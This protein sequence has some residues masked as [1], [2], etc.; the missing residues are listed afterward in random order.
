METLNW[1]GAL[2]SSYVMDQL[3]DIF[4]EGEIEEGIG[5]IVFFNT[6]CL[7]KESKLG[8]EIIEYFVPVIDK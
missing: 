2:P 8:D 7:I 4:P 5:G 1:T 6:K 3:L